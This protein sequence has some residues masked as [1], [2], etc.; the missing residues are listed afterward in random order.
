MTPEPRENVIKSARN[1][2]GVK[3]TIA[4]ILSPYDIM[5]R[6]KFVV[7]EAALRKIEECTP[8][9]NSLRY[10]FTPDYLEQSMEH[11]DLKIC[12]SGCHGRQ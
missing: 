10:Y 7:D 11:T 6:K 12:F 5:N 1:I 9:E 3:T 8:D 4:G 2:P